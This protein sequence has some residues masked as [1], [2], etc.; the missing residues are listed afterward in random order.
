[1]LTTHLEGQASHSPVKKSAQAFQ[2][3]SYKF[4]NNAGLLGACK[5]KI[6]NETSKIG[7]GQVMKI[8]LCH[9]V[10]FELSSKSRGEALVDFKQESDTDSSVF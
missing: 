1:M 8:L 3:K 6:G 9:A 5:A 4:V 2:I 7:R 10:E